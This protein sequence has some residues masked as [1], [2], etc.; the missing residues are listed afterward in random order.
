MKGTK[1]ETLSAIWLSW[2]VATFGLKTRL[3]VLGEHTGTKTKLYQ[4]NIKIQGVYKASLHWLMHLTL[5]K[6]YNYS[7]K[8]A[9]YRMR[10][11][12]RPGSP[13]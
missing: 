8:T 10:K 9:Y 6:D 5:V 2:N 7:N 1:V 12:I 11:A 3:N 13:K 4:N